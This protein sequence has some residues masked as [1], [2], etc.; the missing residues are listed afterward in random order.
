VSR[1]EKKNLKKSKAALLWAERKKIQWAKFSD[2]MSGFAKSVAFMAFFAA[3][4]IL[5][6]FI[7]A[8]ILKGIGL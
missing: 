3:F 4:F 7:S 8:G 2:L 6:D 5:C 1:S